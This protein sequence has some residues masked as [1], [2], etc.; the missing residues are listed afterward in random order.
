MQLKT[1]RHSSHTVASAAWPAF[2]RSAAARATLASRAPP[3]QRQ[4]KCFGQWL[5]IGYVLS[6]V[7]VYASSFPNLVSRLL[8]VKCA[9]RLLQALLTVDTFHSLSR[10]R[11]KSEFLLSVARIW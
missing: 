7:L 9:A 2:G 5:E 11:K 4:V 8:L 1:P 10:E 6:L 3:S